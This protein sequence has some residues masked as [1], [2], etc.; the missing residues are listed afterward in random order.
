LND[1][2]SDIIVACGSL[3]SIANYASQA[4]IQT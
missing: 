1:V 3:L 2:F 4:V